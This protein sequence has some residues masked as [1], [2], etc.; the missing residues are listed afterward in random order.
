M[1]SYRSLKELCATHQGYVMQTST[2]NK[3]LSFLELTHTSTR[4][5]THTH[6]KS[7]LKKWNRFPH[8]LSTYMHIVSFPWHKTGNDITLFLFAVN[9]FKSATSL[10]ADTPGV[11]ETSAVLYDLIAWWL[12]ALWQATSESSPVGGGQ[13]PVLR[14][15]THTVPQHHWRQG[16]DPKV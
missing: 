4:K 2:E 6:T 8:V 1:A 14:V 5:V 3:F 15:P 10:C 13:A 11:S 7:D 12:N 9:E 16:T